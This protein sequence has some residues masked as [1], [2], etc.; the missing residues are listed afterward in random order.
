M[1]KINLYNCYFDD[2]TPFL[3]CFFTWFF[4]TPTALTG[5][6]AII[7]T[8]SVAGI[9]IRFNRQQNRLKNSIDFESTFKHNDKVLASA[10]AVQRLMFTDKDCDLCEIMRTSGCNNPDSKLSDNTKNLSIFFNEWAR[11]ANGVANNIYDQDFL[12]GTYSTTLT[13]TFTKALPFILERQKERPK[14]Y[15]KVCA[16]AITWIIRYNHERNEPV[17]KNLTCALKQ[18]NKYHKFIHNTR[19]KR[20][21]NWLVSKELCEPID[22]ILY[23]K[24]ARYLLLAFY[25]NQKCPSA[26]SRLKKPAIEETIVNMPIILRK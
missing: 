13:V 11:C 26:K 24:K 20:I 25:Y 12:Y 6:L 9:T 15:T 5:L 21:R 10:Q 14:V 19:R 3:K 8:L 22:E 7:G 17:D 23:L 4:D 16:L 2:T 18:L 1:P